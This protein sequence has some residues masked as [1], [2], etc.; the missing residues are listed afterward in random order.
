MSNYSLL[1]KTL[2]RQFLSKNNPLS[3]YF[4]QDIIKKSDKQDIPNKKHIFI[5]G[6]ARAG[7]T[8]LLNKIYDSNDIGSLMYKY[9][10]FIL[11]P[12]LAKIYSNI[13][14]NSKQKKTERFHNDGLFINSD[15]PECLDEVYWIMADNQY[16]DD[17]NFSLKKIDRKII[18][19]YKFLLERFSQIQNKKRLVIKNNNNHMRINQLSNL[20]PSS[21]F[22][23]LFRE[24][25]SHA[26][27]LHQQHLNFTKLQKEDEFI[28]EYMNLIGHREFGLN[29]TRFSYPTDNISENHFTNKND[30]NYWL[31]QWYCSYNWILE[32][33]SYNSPNVMLICYEDLC[34]NFEIYQNLCKSIDLKND[35]DHRFNLLNKNNLKG[36]GDF[37]I[38]LVSKSKEIYLQLKKHSFVG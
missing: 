30:I 16:F 1:D 22:L 13:L 4:Y 31:S 38:N 35:K 17:E 28:L 26:K 25:L 2:H 32:S 9:M 14:G 36:F 8:A 19:G 24:P 23:I 29:A 33:N 37:D 27:S 11:A 21:F 34:D 18:N 20:F 15:S 3:K 10:P 12:D 6:L 5:T 7:T